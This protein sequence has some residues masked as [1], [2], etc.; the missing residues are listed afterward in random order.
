MSYLRAVMAA[1]EIS[2]RVLMLTAHVI[3]MNPAHYTV[4]GYRIK[5]LKALMGDGGKNAKVTGKAKREADLEPEKVEW[6]WRDE[7]DW[8]HGVAQVFEKNYQIW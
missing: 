1:N 3:Q 5:C 4:W 2:F 7:L 6:G 8:V